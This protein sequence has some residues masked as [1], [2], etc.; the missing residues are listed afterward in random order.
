M[1][2]YE[3]LAEQGLKSRRSF[4]TRMVE[5]I[6]CLIELLRT[7]NER[8]NGRRKK[9]TV[10]SG[11]RLNLAAI[12]VNRLRSVELP[13]QNTTYSGGLWLTVVHV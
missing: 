5:E 11:N 13:V 2:K 7:W 10:T 4:L 6:I 3:E 8:I 9:E 1:C 12:G